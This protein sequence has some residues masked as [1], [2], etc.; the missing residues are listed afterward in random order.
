MEDKIVTSHSCVFRFLIYFQIFNTYVVTVTYSNGKLTATASKDRADIKFVNTTR[1]KSRT[2]TGGD[3]PLGILFGGL[4]FGVIG[5][6]VLLEERRKSN[7]K[8]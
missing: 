4:G 6:A 3:A 1:E 8:A 7:K 5:L 2:K